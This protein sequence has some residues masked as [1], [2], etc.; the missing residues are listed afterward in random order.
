MANEQNLTSPPLFKNRELAASAGRKGGS[1]KSERKLWAARLRELKKKGLTDE[2]SKVLAAM[3]TE[4]ESFGFDIL[5][6]LQSIKKECSNAGQKTNV[7]RAMNDLMKSIHGPAERES[8]I[9]IQ[10]NDTNNVQ[11]NIIP[12][13][14]ANHKLDTE[15]ETVSSVPDSSGQDND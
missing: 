14:N 7:A 8:Q 1:V 9:N 4:K 11:I 2:N 12:L 3:M 15:P 6:Y 5:M 13:K 10:T